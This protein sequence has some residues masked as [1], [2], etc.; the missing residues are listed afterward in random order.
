MQPLGLGVIGLGKRA[1]GMMS[2]VRSGGE[3]LFRLVAVC[4]RYQNKVDNACEHFGLPA[5]AG[6]TAYHDL[7]ANPA[8]DAVLVETGA[9]DLSPI[10]CAAL[11]AGKHAMADVP[12]TFTRE[13][14]WEL[15]LAVERTGNVY[16]M[17]EQVRF[18]NFVVRWKE[19]IAKGDIGEPLFIQGEYIH[20]EPYFYFER[21]SDGVP[22]ANTWEDMLVAA[23]DPAFHKA[24][25]NDFKH[26]IKYI[27][28]ELS[29][30][31]KII[32]DRVTHVSC[33][34]S[35]AR[36]FGEAVEMLDLE[37]AL[38]QTERGRTMRIVN[39]FTTPRRGSFAH[40]WYHIQGTEGVLESARPGWG[41]GAGW[42]MNN[43]LILHRDGTMERTNYGWARADAPFG[44]P[45][46]G[47]GGLESFSFQTFYDAIH[48]KPN[49]LNVYATAEAMLPGIIAAESAEAGGI[50]LE[51]PDVRPSA[52]R[53]AGTPLAVDTVRH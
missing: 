50:R 9:Q 33:S 2:I 12:M 53:P 11:Y 22:V 25:R 21:N 8:V 14:T 41:E 24:W 26:P 44:D 48:G 34:A 7:L 30:L 29:P 35:D 45:A 28:H 36:Q 18:G 10:C 17:G 47:H 23:K 39:S 43:E 27:P 40:H 13:D 20:P 37:C 38:M 16:C 6:Y 15:I 19:H 5:S 46:S 1:L 49:E 32:D 4:D 3:H 31:L 52:A 51:V 42:Y